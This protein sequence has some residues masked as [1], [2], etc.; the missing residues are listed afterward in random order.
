LGS[1]SKAIATL[2]AKQWVHCQM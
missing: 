2:H 1:P